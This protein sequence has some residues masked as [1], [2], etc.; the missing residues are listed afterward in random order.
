MRLTSFSVRNFRNLRD[1]QVVDI[2]DAPLLVAAAPNA[3]GKTNF[4]EAISVLLRGK[5]FR[6]SHEKCVRWGEDFFLVQGEVEGREGTAQL[7]V[8]YHTLSKKLRIEQ[9][10]SPISPVLLY[11]NYPFV[12]FLP[13]DTFLFQRGP[14]VRRNF[15]NN[16]LTMSTQYVSALVQYHR[17]LRQR[18][19]ALKDAVA[20]TDVESWTS[21]LIEHADVVWSQ[22]E[23]LVQYINEHAPELATSFLRAPGPLQI[24]L[25]KGAPD[26]VGFQNALEG[27][28]VQ[29][30]RYKYTIYGPHRDD[31]EVMVGGRPIQT[32][33][34]RG[35]IRAVIIALK[36]VV[37]QFMKQVGGVA[38]LLLFDEVLSELDPGRQKKL[39]DLLPASQLFLTCTELPEG[40][41]QRSDVY[42]LDMR[43]LTGIVS[44][45]APAKIPVAHERTPA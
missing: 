2:P 8:Q 9:D 1:A 41:R 6:A 17:A 32:T 5:S 37:Y 18:N 7:A 22:R 25:V 11:T 23:L 3:T 42:L 39:F 27:A 38:P 35:Q 24:R 45:P 15:L 40:V 30:Q 28:W 12:L 44:Q 31:L 43:Q 21:L 34:S 33:L 4:L 16:A 10:T 19:A 36:V 20:M 13:D 26:G 29:E 14:G